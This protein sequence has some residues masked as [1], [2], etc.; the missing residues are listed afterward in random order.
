MQYIVTIEPMIV[1][2]EH[3]LHYLNIDWHYC[4]WGSF[5][6]EWDWVFI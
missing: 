3:L 2:S 1:K 4:T 6:D 5:F